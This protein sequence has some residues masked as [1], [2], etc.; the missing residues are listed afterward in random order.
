MKNFAAAAALVFA[1]SLWTAGAQEYKLPAGFK[2]AGENVACCNMTLYPEADLP[3][4]TAAPE[5]Y[6][7]VYISHFGRHGSRTVSN[8]HVKEITLTWEALA[9]AREAGEL[10]ELGK[11]LVERLEPVYREDMTHTGYLTQKGI[12]QHQGIARR[13]AANF[14]ELLHDGARID[15]VS[16][17]W[18]RCIMSMAAF[19]TTLKELQPGLQMSFQC[20]PALQCT[21]NPPVPSSIKKASKDPALYK[22]LKKGYVP[23]KEV[24]VYF[25]SRD[26]VRK[27]VKDCDAFLY[28]LFQMANN[29][30]DL[31]LNIDLSSLVDAKVYAYYN[32]FSN[33]IVYYH[34]CNSGDFGDQRMSHADTAAFSM[35]NKI[36]KALSGDGPDVDL[37]FAHDFGL[38]AYLSMLGAECTPAGLTSV[39]IDKVFD[40]SVCI[41]MAANLQQLFY[42]NEQGEILVRFLLNERE[43][44]LGGDIK[45]VFGLCYKWSDVRTRLVAVASRRGSFFVEK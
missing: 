15:V 37:L 14:P 27:F 39:M 23:E 4:V 41:P 9:A 34:S 10:S 12:A 24:A 3:A 21:F 19:T 31:D 43:M 13:M 33:R 7:L 5:G 1:A 40:S 6:K 42:K 20:S 8:S 16:S 44:A 25:A 35:M 30:P 26:A 36:D 45:P 32:A 17:I 11:V 28:G 18:P 22:D 38:N 29:A 2:P